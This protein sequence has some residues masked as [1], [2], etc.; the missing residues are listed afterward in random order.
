MEQ[1]IASYDEDAEV[2]DLITDTIVQKIG[3]QQYYLSNGLLQYQGR[4]VL[5]N[6]G[7]LIHQ[8][9][10][11]LHQNGVGGHS[12]NRATYKRITG[13][14]HWPTVRKDVGKWVQECAVCQQVKGEH[15][16]SPRLLKPLNIPQEP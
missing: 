5:G 11:E 9:F 12:G 10:E 15:V 13:Y 3:P 2:N 6:N 4:W 7:D 14:F 8:V 1:I 16:K